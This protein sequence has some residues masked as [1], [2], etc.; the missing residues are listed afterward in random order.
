MSSTERVRRAVTIPLPEQSTA[1]GFRSALTDRAGFHAAID[2]DTLTARIFPTGPDGELLR[3]IRLL[4]PGEDRAR[5]WEGLERFPRYEYMADLKE[6]ALVEV[7]RRANLGTREGVVGAISLMLLVTSN[8]E[9]RARLGAEL[10]VI[11]APS[12][13]PPSGC[14]PSIPD[15]YRASH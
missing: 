2:E 5:L 1:P 15:C 6:D 13:R 9:V 4:A 7:G 8:N 10:D 11:L 12:R 3:P 14:W